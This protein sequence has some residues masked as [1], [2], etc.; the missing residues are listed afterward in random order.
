MLSS[1]QWPRRKKKHDRAVISS[2]QWPS[3]ATKSK[4][5]QWF[6]AH[7]GSRACSSSDFEC[8][9]R[10]YGVLAWIRASCGKLAGSSLFDVLVVVYC[11]G[12]WY[13]LQGVW[14]HF[15]HALT[16]ACAN[17]NSRCGECQRLYQLACTCVLVCCCRVIATGGD[18]MWNAQPVTPKAIKDAAKGSKRG[19]Y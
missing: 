12:M 14:S 19:A 9:V 8:F 2:A 6:R 4:L 17:Q 15:H 11:I 13:M 16:C 1:A 7:S 10:Q 3:G 5:E 18:A